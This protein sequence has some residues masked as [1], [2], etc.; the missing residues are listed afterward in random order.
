MRGGGLLAW[1]KV[2]LVLAR[3]AELTMPPTSSLGD[4]RACF[5]W[6]EGGPSYFSSPTWK[7]DVLLSSSLLSA[8]AGGVTGRPEGHLWG[9]RAAQ[10]VSQSWLQTEAC[11]SSISLVSYLRLCHLP[12]ICDNCLLPVTPAYHHHLCICHLSYLSSIWPCLLKKYFSYLF[13]ESRERREKEG[14]KHQ[15]VVASCTPPTGNL[16]C[17]PGMC[18]DWE[19]NRQPLVGRPALSPLIW[20]S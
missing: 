5:L 1:P 7:R 18:P 17:H 10:G 2:Q 13:S 12:A 9:K 4:L 6:A 20:P 15:C 19:L 8:V 16:A 11:L 3:A 14:E